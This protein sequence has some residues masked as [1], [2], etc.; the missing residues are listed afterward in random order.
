MTTIKTTD[1]KHAI[2]FDANKKYRGYFTVHSYDISDSGELKFHWC[3][4]NFKTEVQAI[5]A[6]KRFAKSEFGC[7]LEA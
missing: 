7:P 6:S 2:A 3:V 1:G 5:R 4:G